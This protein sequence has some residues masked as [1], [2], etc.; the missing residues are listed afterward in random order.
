MLAPMTEIDLPP[1]IGFL[2]PAFS[3]LHFG[4][5]FAFHTLSVVINTNKNFNACFLAMA[6]QKERYPDRTR[7]LRHFVDRMESV[8]SGH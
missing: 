3:H 4:S 1:C 8:R 6:V 2:I 7:F 5:D